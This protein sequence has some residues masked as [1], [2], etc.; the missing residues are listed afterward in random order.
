MK[1]AL[2]FSII[3]V[4]AIC[5]NA[6]EFG[7]SIDAGLVVSQ[8]DGDRKGG[9]NK[10]GYTIG[11]N[12][13]RFV[14]KDL[15]GFNIGLQYIRKGSHSEES[16]N[17]SYYK[18]ELHYIEMPLKAFCRW[19]KFDFNAGMTIG[20]LLKGKEDVDGYGLKDPVYPFRK[21]DF[22]GTAGARYKLTDHIWAGA[23]FCY[24]LIAIR[25]YHSEQDMYIVSGQHN[26]LLSFCLT[27]DFHP[28]Q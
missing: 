28:R 7:A 24:S 26:N 3:I 25:K 6:Q 5:T 4:S 10:M 16:E 18:T 11:A 22:S 9:Y 20:Y 1:K 8:V 14:K 17:S 21:T 2:L 13:Y 27:Y 23:Q 15:F 12:A 19:K